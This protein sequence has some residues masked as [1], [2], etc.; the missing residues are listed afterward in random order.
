MIASESEYSLN[1]PLALPIVSHETELRFTKFQNLLLKW[2]KTFNL[3]GKNT[4]QQ[5][6]NL[7]IHDSLS[8]APHLLKLPTGLIV[9]M[10]SGA[11]F[12]GLILACVLSE[13]DFI[14][15]EKDRNKAIFLKET[16]RHLELNNVTVINQRVN[17]IHASMI[18]QPITA[19]IARA[20]APL[21]TLLDW[22]SH[23]IGLGERPPNHFLPKLLF[24]KGIGYNKELTELK[25]TWYIK[26]MEIYTAPHPGKGVIIVIKEFHHGPILRSDPTILS[27]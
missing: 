26:H 16:I 7:H 5:I 2:N 22:S 13:Y 6:H 23:I 12:P 14:L 17:D 21:S 1:L 10:G 20:A 8:L 19:I 15:I 27:N 24:P 11:G 3:I 18:T 4:A 25:S 9:D